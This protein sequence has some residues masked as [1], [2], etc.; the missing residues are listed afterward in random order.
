MR[1]YQ[2]VYVRRT[3]S[4]S[5]HAGDGLEVRR[6]GKFPLADH[7]S[8]QNREAIGSSRGALMAT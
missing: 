5:N 6:T 8:D 4:P 3:F 7:L 2:T 1:I